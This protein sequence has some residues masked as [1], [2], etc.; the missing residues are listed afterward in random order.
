[1]I[2][3]WGPYDFQSPVI[4]NTNP[5]DTN[6]EM[7]FKLL[8]PKGKWKIKSFHGVENISSMSG[9]FPAEIT[10]LKIKADRTDILIE[11][12]YN[13]ATVI[14]PFGETIAAGKTY[15]FSFREFFQPMNWHVSWYSFD[16]TSN[17]ITHDYL[18]PPNTKQEP[19]HSEKTNKLDYAWWGGQKG[20]DGD[21][22]RQ[23]ITVAETSSNIPNG[24]YE[25]GVTWDDAVRV[26]VDG[27]LV[28]DEWNPSL[29]NFDEAPHKTIQLQLSGNHRFR[30]EHVELGG[31]ATLSLK[32]RQI[33]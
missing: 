26:Y 14:T 9:A 27:K 28:I 10:A 33:E 29:Y 24:K 12:E 8:G 18:F 16:S 11:L 30:V 23:F 13:G 22:Y 17:P 31:F 7:K 3:E 25:L 19:F 20:D 6:G 32:L 21:Q 4:W 5:T 2:T 15:R 1:M